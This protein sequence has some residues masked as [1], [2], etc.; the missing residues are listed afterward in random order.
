MMYFFLNEFP[1]LKITK[2]RTCSF[3]IINHFFN[4]TSI[5]NLTYKKHDSNR[6]IFKV[7]DF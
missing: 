1:C 6:Q 5:N 3:V 2:K 7:C 4:F